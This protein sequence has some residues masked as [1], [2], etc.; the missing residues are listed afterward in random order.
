MGLTGGFGL[1]RSFCRAVFT[2]GFF[3]ESVAGVDGCAGSFDT[4]A[5]GM[6]FGFGVSA[7]G[8]E[9]V[10]AG[11]DGAVAIG[12]P[13]GLTICEATGAVAGFGVPARGAESVEAGVDGADAIGGPSGL[14]AFAAAGAAAVFGVSIRGGAE[15]GEAGAGGAVAIGGTA[16]LIALGA[17]D[18]AAIFGA[19]IRGGVE[20]GE[21]AT[22]GAVA[23]GAPS[24]LI[25]CEAADGA[26]V[27]GAS[28]GGGDASGEAATDGAVAIGA[29]SG[30]ILCEAT[31][32]G[33]WF[34]GAAVNAG[35][36]E[37]GELEG[38][39]ACSFCGLTWLSVAATGGSCSG[40][41]G[42]LFMRAKLTPIMAAP[43]SASPPAISFQLRDLGLV[44]FGRSVRGP[45]DFLAFARAG[46]S[47]C[48]RRLSRSGEL[49]LA[50]VDAEGGGALGAGVDDSSA[51]FNSASMSSEFTCRFGAPCMA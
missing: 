27:F 50:A 30:P 3:L 21:A 44:D 2:S 36:A 8:A 19:S 37:P 31:S 1:P 48:G 29:P 40:R 22:D 23:F 4:C 9:S 11:V 33:A 12:A 6:A 7:G 14:I 10:E 26:A 16:G 45:I 28:A 24:G 32:A 15:S 35:A 5:V 25:A 43:A 20:G 13:S 38:S 17:A 51:R 42:A 18:G 49:D 46:R 34:G 41:S 39:R 47:A